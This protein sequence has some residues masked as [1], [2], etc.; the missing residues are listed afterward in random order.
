VGAT[1]KAHRAA[2]P[3]PATMLALPMHRTVLRVFPL[4]LQTNIITDTVY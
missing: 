1:E 2:A 3:L 4:N